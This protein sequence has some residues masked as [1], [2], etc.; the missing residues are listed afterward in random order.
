[1]F[2]PHF[3][4]A[5]TAHSGSGFK[6]KNL[7]VMVP[8]DC[9]GSGEFRQRFHLVGE[10]LRCVSMP[11]ISDHH[12][13]DKHKQM[14]ESHNVKLVIQF[15]FDRDCP[16]DMTHSGMRCA[17]LMHKQLVQRGHTQSAVKDALMTHQKDKKKV[18]KIVG[19]QNQN[20][21]SIWEY[22]F[23]VEKVDLFC[24]AAKRDE[25]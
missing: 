10:E 8:I 19:K 11:E 20:K 3:S 14:Q 4:A 22:K 5:A 2:K 24:L 6:N 12:K 13:D 15:C 1:M 23:L 25:G 7:A 17:K 9:G 16:P 21:R 18:G